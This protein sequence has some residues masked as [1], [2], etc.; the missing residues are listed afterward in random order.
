MTQKTKLLAQVG[1]ALFG[2]QWQTPLAAALGVG[3]RTVRRWASG[4][5]EVPDGVWADIAKLCLTR[6]QDLIGWAGRLGGN[7]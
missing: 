4:D 1:E 6:A 3:D 5:T 2:P 7:A